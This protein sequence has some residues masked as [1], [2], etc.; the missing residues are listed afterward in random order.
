MTR[1]AL[2]VGIDHYEFATPLFGC[3]NDAHEVKSTLDRHAD[4]TKNFDTELLVGSGQA[5]PVIRRDF[6]QGV[7][8]LFAGDDEIALLYFA[9]HGCI[10]QTGGYLLCSDSADGNDGLALHEVVTM[11]NDS[12]AKNRIIVLDSCHSGI[13]G[14]AQINDHH[15]SISTGVTILT[16]STAKQYATEVEGSGLFSKLFV[17]ALIGGAADLLGEVTPGAVYAHIDQSLGPWYQRPLF[18]TNVTT[19]TSLRTAQAPIPLGTL[20]KLRVYFSE[21]GFELELDPSFE[22]TSADP[23]KEHKEIFSDLQK[24]A[25]VNLVRPVGEDHMY[26]A[27]MNSKSCR[28]TLL[29]EHYWKLLDAGMI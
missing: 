9:G 27:A 13:A 16:A 6:R 25:G 29:G 7:Q 24:M 4:G 12:R 28:L 20:K 1:K 10:E 5:S 11:A 21:S 3:V 8:E 17:H 23:T 22:P 15:V 26:Y 2:I 14:N 18:K 19:F